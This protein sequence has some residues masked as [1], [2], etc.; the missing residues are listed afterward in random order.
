MINGKR[1]G[2]EDISVTLPYGVLI[3][4]QNIEYGDEKEIEAVYG[5]GSNPTG[6]GNGNYSA[7]GKVTLLKEEHDKLVDYAKK[8][9]KSLYGISPFTIVVSYANEDQPTKT[10]VLKACK[11]KK[12]S[13]S[14]GQGDKE[15]KAEIELAILDGIW[16]DGLRPN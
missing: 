2:W 1:Y 11:I 12:V 14:S 8:Q 13:S 15:V 9:K 10:D 3:D 6:Y 5:K 7:E 4:I 16:R